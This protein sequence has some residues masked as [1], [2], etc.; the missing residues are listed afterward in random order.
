MRLEAPLKF[1]G[2]FDVYCDEY[3]KPD[4]KKTGDSQ[5][6]KNVFG[7][8][9]ID[10]KGQV[11][12]SVLP[13]DDNEYYLSLTQGKFSLGGHHH[14]EL[15]VT[16][17]IGRCAR[18]Y[19]TLFG[20]APSGT[21]DSFVSKYKNIRFTAQIAIVGVT[22]LDSADELFHKVRFSI[23]GL[24]DF[25]ESSEKFAGYKERDM[26][27]LDSDEVK[28]LKDAEYEK[29]MSRNKEDYL[30]HRFM[31]NTIIEWNEPET[32]RFKISLWDDAKFSLEIKAVSGEFSG[33]N[34]GVYPNGYCVLETAT[35]MSLKDF[36]ERV[37]CLQS[38]F[39]FL[40]DRHVAITK[41]YG[42]NNDKTSWPRSFSLNDGLPVN[43][44]IYFHNEGDDRI[45]VGND[46]FSCRYVNV[47]DKFEEYLN[48]F[49]NQSEDTDFII[50]KNL[51]LSTL[52]SSP[53]QMGY[54]ENQIRALGDFCKFLCQKFFDENPGNLQKG[55]EMLLKS[56]PLQMKKEYRKVL[57]GISNKNKNE[58]IE[59]IMANVR[60]GIAHPEN[61]DNRKEYKNIVPNFTVVKRILMLLAKYYLLQWIY[62]KPKANEI[63]IQKTESFFDLYYG[64]IK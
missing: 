20:I 16:R 48:G 24:Y 22:P 1:D 49:V 21:T 26:P 45:E 46:N 6:I 43:F 28:N 42:Y 64:R 23:D 34:R 30:L 54:L 55:F 39:C 57:N 18:Q 40:F 15:R 5:N 63:L 14:R 58:N 3:S 12:L 60:N 44:D 8:L 59:F 52:A 17:I 33:Q 47:Q 2:Y 62:D 50:L 29:V 37:G 41:L 51:Y 19:I 35:A 36:F 61:K 56:L 11:N 7:N 4:G 38:F 13:S 25:L 10:I 31:K 32:E 27:Y 53:L 9:E